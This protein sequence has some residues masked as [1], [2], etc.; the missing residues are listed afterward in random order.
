MDLK[1]AKTV[2]KSTKTLGLE[3]VR[4]CQVMSTVLGIKIEKKK[5]HCG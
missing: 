3:L 1:D 2:G 5:H 4:S